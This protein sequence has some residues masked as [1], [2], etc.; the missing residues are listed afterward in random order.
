MI[1]PLQARYSRAKQMMVRSYR[2]QLI[3][4]LNKIRNKNTFDSVEGVFVAYLMTY[5]NILK[6]SFVYLICYSNT[7]KIAEG[8][9]GLSNDLPLTKE[10]I[11]DAAEQVLRRFG[12]EKSSV[13]DVARV[14]G[15]SHGTLY[16]HFASKSE[17]RQAVTERWLGQTIAKPLEELA[18]RSDG[19]AAKQLHLWLETLISF[20]RNYASSDSEM[21]AMYASV[22][23][24]AVEMID[25][26]INQLVRQIAVILDRGI[27][28]GEFKPCQSIDVAR[29]I[30]I[31]TAK[32][33]HPS[34]AHEWNPEK[35]DKEFELV[36]ELLQNGI[37]N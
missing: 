8:G 23:T 11:L 1:L 13:M 31:A 30:F 6:L 15:V 34:H 21:F 2:W 18:E 36:W 4:T 32:F 24:E 33:H 7:E 25:S 26:H 14:L 20:K 10:Q 37:R 5:Y 16:R 19:S 3:I 12:P 27:K 28:I 35:S 29:A 9:K 22:T 17:L